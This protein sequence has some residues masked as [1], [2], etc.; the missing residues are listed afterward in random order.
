MARALLV[1]HCESSG[2]APEAPLTARGEEQ[3]VALAERLSAHPIDHLVSS[4]YLRAR[5]T[6][7]PFAERAGLAVQIEERLAERRMSQ[8]PAPHWREV[9]RRSFTDPH[10]RLP[11]GESGAEALARGSAAIS[12]V[13]AAGH[14]LPVLV[15]HG[16]LLS[17]VLHS[18]DPG[19]GY[20][21]WSSLANP[22]VFLLETRG[23]GLR[24]ERV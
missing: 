19:F 15:S 12:A 23:G 10:F 13:L 18:I 11:G 16:Q 6:I 9:V 4:P 20:S 3:A 22:D 21:G 14:R 1:R 7:A 2:P 5:A 17:L 8:E 24:F